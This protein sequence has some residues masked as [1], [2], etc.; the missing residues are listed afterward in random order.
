[1]YSELSHCLHQNMLKKVSLFKDFDQGFMTE[2][3]ANLHPLS[4]LA[5]H[6]IV[7]KGEIGAEMYFIASGHVQVLDP[8]DNV[9]PVVVLTEGSYF[10]EIGLMAKITRTCTVS[11]ITNVHAYKLSGED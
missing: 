7:R 4:F 6:D 9:S 2:L 8:V 11:A 5:G 1:M 10:G 3:S